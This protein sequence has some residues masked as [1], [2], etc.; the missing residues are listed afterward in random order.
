ML[1]SLFVPTLIVAL[2]EIGDKTQLLALLLAAR[3]RRPWPIIW[4]MVV[5]T[6]ANHLVA[7]AVGN[8]VAGLLSPALLSWILAASFIIVALWTLI[9]DKLDDDESSNLKR[10]GPFLTTL[11]AFFL[12]EMGDKTQVATVMLAAQYPHFI[13]VVIGTTLGMLLANVPVVLAGNFA[14]D[15]LP[16]TLIRRLAATAFLALALYAAYQAL[17]LSGLVGK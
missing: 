3:F 15:R 8:W 14:A 7:G 2:A 16:L 1:E 5:A 4:G 9:P 11:I 10:Y 6:L 13:M 17:L 12:A